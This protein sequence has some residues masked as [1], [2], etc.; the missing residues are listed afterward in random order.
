MWVDLLVFASGLAGPAQAQYDFAPALKLV[1]P[2]DSLSDGGPSLS[3]DN[4]TL[5]YHSYYRDGAGGYDLW[6]ATRPTADDDFDAAVN[7]GATLNTTRD[8]A[9][10][11]ISYDGLSLYFNSG[12]TLGDLDMYVATRRSTS[13]SFGEPVELEGINTSF[14]DGAPDI[15]ANGLTL[16]FTTN[17]PGGYGNR[18][19]YLATRATTDDPFTSV[20]NLGA[21][22]NTD[23]EE[24]FPTLAPDGLSIIFSSDRPGGL[25]GYDLYSIARSA[26]DAEWSEPRNLGPNVNS[27]SDED[28][29]DFAWDWSGIVFGSNRSGD[30]GAFHVYQAPI[31]SHPQGINGDVDLDGQLTARDIDA[32][33]GAIRAGFTSIVYDLNHD[34]VVNIN[35][36][37]Q[38]VQN[39][40]MTWFGDANLDGEFNSTDLVQV[41]AAGTYESDVSSVWPTGDFNGDARTNSTDLV[42]ALADGGYEQG[43]RAAVS[44]VPEPASFITSMVSLI[45]FAIRR[46]HVGP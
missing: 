10:P 36:H 16:L 14:R 31:L 37:L 38:W 35:D 44:A 4:R 13:D 20:E 29:P 18:D 19:I 39:L 24:R 8:D 11:E 9:N 45:G 21:T 46:R 2:G 40:K 42:V 26:L 33:A 23:D 15:S 32:I 1:L 22:V 12:E 30:D 27:P 43:P 6:M 28:N 7:L 17:K 3:S 34:N 41:L 25:G 5:F